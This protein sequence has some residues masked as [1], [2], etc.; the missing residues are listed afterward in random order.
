MITSERAQWAERIIS[1]LAYFLRAAKITL[2]GL[3]QLWKSRRIYPKYMSKCS[4]GSTDY[5]CNFYQQ[6]LSNVED[7]GVRN[8]RQKRF[9]KRLLRQWRKNFSFGS[10]LFTQ[11]WCCKYGFVYYSNVQRTFKDGKIK[12]TVFTRPHAMKRHKSI[13]PML[14][15][16][17]LGYFYNAPHWGGGYF[18]PP[19][20]SPKLLGRF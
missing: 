9:T 2:K 4:V 11:C 8:F 18:E 20:W 16:A 1:Y 7:I 14:T 3:N 6:I 10:A 17:P 19:L 5:V 15:R 12:S 13:G